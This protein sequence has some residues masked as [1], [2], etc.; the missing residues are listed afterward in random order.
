MNFMVKISKTCCHIRCLLHCGVQI[1]LKTHHMWQQTFCQAIQMPQ[2]N[3]LVLFR[4]LFP[5]FF[6]LTM[7]WS[8]DSR[9]TSRPSPVT[10]HAGSRCQSCPWPS[11]WS[12]SSFSISPG[13]RAAGK[14]CLLAITWKIKQYQWKLIQSGILGAIQIILNTL[15]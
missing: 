6:L 9:P 12:P 8:R 11:S 5:S 10:A 2:K 15:C 14:S 1:A 3:Y 7:S 13:D 4:A